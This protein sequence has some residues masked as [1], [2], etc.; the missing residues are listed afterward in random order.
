MVEIPESG[1]RPDYD[2]DAGPYGREAFPHG[3]LRGERVNDLWLP[4]TEDDFESVHRSKVGART[5]VTLE[6]I[7]L[8]ID[9]LSMESR[10]ER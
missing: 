10:G 8:V 9:R 6:S 7:A 2:E 4:L 5:E 1:N 3:G